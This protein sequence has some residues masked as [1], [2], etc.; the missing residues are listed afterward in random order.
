MKGFIVAIWFPAM[1][2]FE[3][4]HSAI[5]VEPDINRLIKNGGLWIL[6]LIA[7][8]ILVIP[9]TALAADYPLWSPPW[10]SNSFVVILLTLLV[11]DLWTYWVH[12]L[13]H[14]RPLLWR[15]HEIHHLDQHLDT[16]TAVRFHVGEV[17]L[18]AMIRIGPIIVFA[19]PIQTVIL[20]ELI[21]LISTIF[22]HSNIRLPL[23][24]ERVIGMV[25]ITPQ[26]HRVHHHAEQ[27]FTDSNYG[28][29]LSIW[30]RLFSS[31]TN[32]MAIKDL[33]IGVESAEDKPFFHLIL[34]PFIKRFA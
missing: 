19:I 27:R 16:S 21:L 7:S 2:V 28:A 12:R 34:K 3:R 31:R 15:L 14:E 25:L 13:Y 22:H 20:F 17:V 33:K 26:I 8:P 1:F 11:L 9:V 10:A 32:T 29:V 5:S 6:T 4:L 24:T 30:D 23:K 18:S